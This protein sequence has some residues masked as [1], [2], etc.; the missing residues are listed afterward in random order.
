MFNGEI[1]GA[2]Q[3]MCMEQDIRMREVLQDVAG[4]LRS[5]GLD[6]PKREAE[7]LVMAATER[8]RLELLTDTDLRIESREEATLNAML[9][10]R[11]EREPLQ[12]IVGEAA[13]YGR[14]FFVT[15]DVLIPR[16]E[17]EELVE[18]VLSLPEDALAGGIVDLGTGSG[19]IP[20]TV[21]CERENVSCTGVDISL[22][23]LDVARRNATRHGARVCWTEADMA[24]ENLHRMLDGPASVLVSNPPYVPDSEADRL[25]PEVRNHEPHLALF[26]GADPLRYYRV[27]ASQAPKLLRPGGWLMVEIHADGGLGVCHLFEQAGLKDVVLRTD[28]AGKDRIVQARQP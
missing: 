6:N 20:I 19:C 18:C 16:P 25:Q 1:Y 26:S 21:A 10:R 12:Y 22:P 27:I 13:F 2:N 24:A 8:S 15:P 11:L 4:Q 3:I 28:L 23:A 7:W 14:S 5:A 17:T 9:S